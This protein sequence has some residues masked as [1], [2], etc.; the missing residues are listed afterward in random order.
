MGMNCGARWNACNGVMYI[1]THEQIRPRKEL[2]AAIDFQQHLF[3]AGAPVCPVMT[4]K[5]ARFIELIKQ[6]ELAFL[7][8]VCHYI[9]YYS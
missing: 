3:I 5:H 6:D 4:S 9:W 7:A 1:D 8:H 2:D